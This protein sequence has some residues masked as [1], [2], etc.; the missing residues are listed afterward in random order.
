MLGEAGLENREPGQL[1]AAIATFVGSA[2][3]AAKA[4]AAAVASAAAAAAAVAAVR[5]HEF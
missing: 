4:A 3:A 2:V 1:R 5:H